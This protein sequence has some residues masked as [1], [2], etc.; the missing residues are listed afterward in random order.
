MEVEMSLIDRL[1]SNTKIPRDDL[2]RYILTCPRRYKVYDIPKRNGK[3]MRTIAQPSAPVKSLQ[4]EVVK[5][6]SEF[7]PVH[8]SATGYR[9]GVSIFDNA[10]AHCQNPYLLKMDF[11]NFF[12]SLP[13]HEVL[14][15]LRAHCDLITPD[16]LKLIVSTLFRRV[17]R[18][19]YELS[20]GAPSSPFIS[21]TFMYNFDERVSKLASEKGIVYTRYA[22]D[23]AFSTGVKNILFELPKIISQQ[24]LVEQY[25]PL[26]INNGKT[27]F[28][29]KKH[30]RHVTGLVLSNDG[31]VSLGRVRKREIRTLA[32][33][34]TQGQ[35]DLEKENYFRGLLAHA[36]YIEP[37]LWDKLKRKYGLTEEFFKQ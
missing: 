18:S 9:E 22:D 16:E 36:K 15:N 7:C 26:S 8:Q 12:P 4:R 1:S 11:T 2:E 17:G 32:Y 6:L 31:T 21:N 28:S 10:K 29:S 33:L 27:V 20:I 5:I 37:S 23:L 13:A 24:L 35:L 25:S 34:Y 30:N 19:G 3:G 14:E